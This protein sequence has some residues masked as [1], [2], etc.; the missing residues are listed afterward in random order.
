[1]SAVYLDGSL[2]GDAEG[3]SDS[4]QDCQVALVQPTALLT[5][6]TQLRLSPGRRGTGWGWQ[7]RGRVDTG[8]GGGAKRHRGYHPQIVRAMIRTL[9]GTSGAPGGYVKT[10][11][12]GPPTLGV[13]DSVGLR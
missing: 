7:L 11:M 10:Q 8:R 13:S 4:K 1:M 6:Q 9:E 3:A 2:S 5:S 12:A